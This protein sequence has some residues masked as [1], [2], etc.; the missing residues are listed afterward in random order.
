MSVK[1]W[2]SKTRI[3]IR[4]ARRNHRILKS[5][6]YRKSRVEAE[7]VRNVHSIEKGLSIA[8]PRLGFGIAKIKELL[9]LCETYRLLKSES[10]ECLYFARDAIAAYLDFHAAKNY[11]DENILALKTEYEKFTATLPAGSAGKKFG[12]KETLTLADISFDLEQVELL[13]NT[14]HSIREFSDKKVSDEDLEKAISLAQRCPSA[15]NRQAVRVYSING[16]T[17]VNEMENGLQGIGGFASD[18][19]KFLL[20]TGKKSAYREVERNQFIVSASIFGAYLSLTLHAYKIANCL[21]QR[22]LTP[23]K[24]WD[25]ICNK[26]KIPHD[27]QL[28]MLIGIGGYREETTVPVSRRYS[29]KSIYRK[30]D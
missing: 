19:D 7:I 25:K 17:F 4:E 20:I 28:V 8:A 15:C 11:V 9:A 1:T 10:L 21:I 13:F 26:Y 12:G 27:E 6:K 3:S 29:L 18:V 14:R 22:P 23:N 24:A 5:P 30:L 16:E 2:I